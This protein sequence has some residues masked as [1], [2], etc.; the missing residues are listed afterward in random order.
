LHFGR[1]DCI[2]NKIDPPIVA[3]SKG[4]HIALLIKCPELVNEIFASNMTNYDK[5]DILD[6]H[7]RLVFGRSVLLMNSDS[8]WKEK[9]K[10]L[11]SAFNFEKLK[12]MTEVFKTS[13]KEMGD[14]W[15]KE[16]KEGR[17]EMDV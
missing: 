10:I 11:S 16:I 5:H 13:V 1:Q 8:V 14:N 15:V 6:Y 7:L 3:V 4:A 12:L 2:D 17:D 9:R